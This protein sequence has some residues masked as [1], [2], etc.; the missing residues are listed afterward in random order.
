MP[1]VNP[2]L[3]HHAEL[4]TAERHVEIAILGAGFAGI[5]AAIRFKQAGISDF[6][7]LEKANE[8]GGVWRENTYPGCACDVPSALYSYS[9]APNPNWSRMFAEQVEIKT[10]LQETAERFGVMPYVM[11]N[12]EMLDSSWDD[13]QKHWV[14]KTSAGVFF[15]R[16][17]V[18]ACGPMH[19]PIYP[20][21]KGLKT[22]KGMTFH[23]ARWRHDY[24]LQGK[25]V[26]VIGT[27]ASAIQ[28]VP[29]IQ[30]QVA[31]LT[32]IQRTPQWVLPKLDQALPKVAQ[33]IFKYVPITQQT[34]RGTIYGVFE[35]LNCSMQHP[36]LMKK[37]QRLAVYN[38]NRA[39]KSDELRSK[40]TPDFIIGCKRVLQ[41]NDWYPALVQPN[42]DIVHSGV[43]EVKGNKIIASDG[44]SHEV[45]AIILATGF[46]IS[47]PKVLNRVRGR[48]GQTVSELWQGSPE[49]Y[50]GTMTA[51][52]PNAFLMF[53]PNL[54]VSSSAF[55]IIEAQLNYILDALKQVRLHKIK[56]IDVDLE[57]QV[58][59]NR[60]VQDAL[61]DSVWNTGGCQSYFIDAN[62][63]NS[64]LWPWSTF[65]MRHQLSRFD[66]S[67]YIVDEGST[68]HKTAVI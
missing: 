39:V 18:M 23:S 6:V 59:F 19:E 40:L 55:I 44:T 63:R 62:G 34:L 49:G 65:E 37:I 43:R 5:G 54:A 27:G 2:Q 41:S 25:R 3:N 11:L 30:P 52:C 12:H 22:F 10:Y 46:E 50:M 60:K 68:T 29:K 7:V 15:A 13:Q 28:F 45:D 17:I 35:T 56:T 24:D 51:D 64:T 53:G 1:Q 31:K 8:I 33:A 57:N 38:I 61:Q 21:I 16:F 36:Q 26:A 48:S 9:F 4:A 66:L 67:Q 42:V 20:D 32:L 58:Q 14:V 47:A